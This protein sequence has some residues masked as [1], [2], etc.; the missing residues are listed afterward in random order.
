[1]TDH[2][3]SAKDELLNRIK[4]EVCQKEHR[5]NWDSVPKDFRFMLMDRV[6]KRYAEAIKQDFKSSLKR[7]IEEEIHQLQELRETMLTDSAID[8]I[9]A[10]ISQC[11]KFLELLDELEPNT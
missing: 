7:M 6:C 4:D 11:Q 5:C 10:K 3:Q 1:M 8:E 9:E 2:H